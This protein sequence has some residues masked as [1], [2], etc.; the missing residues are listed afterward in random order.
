MLPS[1]LNLIVYD[2]L[3]LKKTQCLSYNSDAIFVLIQNDNFIFSIGFS[4]ETIILNK[5]NLQQVGKFK[6]KG[7]SIRFASANKKYLILSC[8]V[9]PNQNSD[10]QDVDLQ[11]QQGQLEIYD[12]QDVQNIYFI[13][14]INGAYRFGQL[15]TNNPNLIVSI[16]E[17]ENNNKIPKQNHNTVIQYDIKKMELINILPQQFHG[18]TIYASQENNL[19][20]FLTS[21]RL[22]AIFDE[23]QQKLKVIEIKSSGSILS[24]TINNGIFYA[25]PANNY[26][27]EIN[28]QKYEDLQSQINYQNTNEI[29]NE[30]LYKVQKQNTLALSSRNYHLQI[31]QSTHNSQTLM[32]FNEDGLFTYDLEKKQVIANR[33]E[34]SI[35]CVGLS[36]D[37]EEK[38]VAVG[39]FVGNVLFYVNNEDFNSMPL[40]QIQVPDSVRCLEFSHCD[41]YLLIGCMNGAVYRFDIQNIHSEINSVPKQ[42]LQING[43][44]TDIKCS[45]IQNSEIKYLIADTSGFITIYNDLSSQTINIKQIQK[46]HAH[47]AQDKESIMNP[48]LFGSLHIKS[49]I[50]KAV[51]GYNTQNFIATCSEDQTGRI[52]AFN[53]DNF[54]VDLCQTLE[55]YSLA[56]TAIDW[57]MMDQNIGELYVQ[58]SDD[59]TIGIYSPSN[60]FKK[61]KTLNTRFINEWHTLTYLA[62]EKNGK[63]LAIGGQSGYLFIY[64]IMEEKWVYAEKIHLGGIE[65]LI[66][67]NNKIITCSSDCTI[68]M[69][70]IK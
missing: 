27:L 17:T 44:I 34:A 46:Y 43:T 69:F 6:T 16:L 23:N 50:W 42:I 62:L 56:C 4:G 24:A 28:I 64:D 67:K 31:I 19:F 70:T 65:G 60:N 35:T 30:N 22:L 26:L 12:I 9:S 48:Q 14:Q 40:K 63:H 61:L 54:Q 3:N 66:W 8:E 68:N 38:I 37:K 1:G 53:E 55:G 21:Q 2:I 7:R 57:Q 10:N 32:V 29:N 20:V 58:C 39:D 51:W 47:K 59:Q 33:Q 45:H 49:E 25:C 41:N 15:S 18:D 52:H 11:Q 5:Q 36:T 13:G